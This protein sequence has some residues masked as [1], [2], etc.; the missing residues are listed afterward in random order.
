MAHVEEKRQHSLVK[1]DMDGNDV[2]RKT[3]DFLNQMK[4][5]T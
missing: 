5:K 3:K 4:H 2:K 1:K